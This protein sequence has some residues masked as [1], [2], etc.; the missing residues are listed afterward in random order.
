MLTPQASRIRGGLAV[1]LG[2]A[3]LGVMPGR[4]AAPLGPTTVFINELH[5][6]NTGTDTGEAIEVAGPAGTD[7]TGWSLV[8][9][10]GSVGSVYS[11]TSL[12]SLIPHLSGGFGV[13]VVD[14]PTNG[15]QN[16]SPDGIALVD[17]GGTVVQFLSYEG[18]FVA[19]G[20]PADGLTSTDI[21]VA[22]PSSTPVG[23]SLQLMGTGVFAEDF[24]WALPSPHTFG[25]VNTGQ[26]FGPPVPPEACGDPSTTIHDVQGSGSASPLDGSV[27]A[28]EGVVV[29][30]F[31]GPTPHSDGFFLQEPDA[32]ADADPATSE[33]IFV[34]APGAIDVGSGDRVRVRGTVGEFFERT[35]ITDVSLVLVCSAGNPLPAPTEL[36]LPVAS[37]DAFERVEGMRVRFPQALVIAEYFNFDRFGEIVLSSERRYQPTA[38]VE[39]GTA[40]IALA[41][42]NALDQI[43]LDDGR[44]DQNP[45]PARHPNGAVFDLTN[46]FRGGDTVANLTGVMDFGFG[47]YRVQ[48]TEGAVYTAANRRPAEPEAVGGNVKVASFNLLN[49]FTTLSSA[50]PVCGPAQDQD[51]RGADDATELQRQQDKIVSALAALGAD[52]VG[53]LELENAPTDA[54]LQT[55]VQALN[56]VVGA[57]TY[58]SVATG[59]IG[60]D[61]IKVAFLYKPASVATLGPHA[62]LDSTV[63][64]R[65]LDTKNRPALAQTFRHTASGGVFTS[66]VNHLKSKGSGC[67]DV[68]DPDTGDGSGNCNGTRQ[69]AARALVDWLATDPTGSGDEDFLVLGDL[70][71]YAKE[72]PIDALRARGYTD[73]VNAFGGELAY[74]FVFDGQLGYLH[75]ALA[76]QGLAGEVTGTSVWHIN[77]DEPDLLDYDTSFK[78][79]AQDALYE[80]NAFRSSDHDPVLVGLGV[81]DELAP[82]LSVSVSP[83]TLQPPNHRYRTVTATVSASDD[84]DPSPQVRLV[85]V[86]SSEPDNGIDDGNTINDIVVVDDLTLKL[87]AERSGSGSGRT[88]TITYQASDR[89]GNT[90]IQTATVVVPLSRAP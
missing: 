35:E 45:D 37:L 87:R 47:L 75:H 29:G 86:T 24:T 9:Y 41:Q 2:L 16:G 83:E 42:A 3:L 10:N 59:P 76:S 82:I 23:S 25:A 54:P 21:G 77:A 84:T 72:D 80:P 39:P 52:V 43:T 32:E 49:Y 28:V 55:L 65:F 64:P 48:A 71:S 58:A 50:G 51:C 69:A 8:L 4:A 89:C 33:G 63:D 46:R 66:V 79:P 31:Q 67:D 68:G 26:T 30:D 40:A 53:L 5:Y 61:A 11:T 17:P 7:L 18:T 13:V 36:A 73:L 56:D 1:G 70:N 60:T 88:Y 27:V 6:D 90:T 19:V 62:I 20:G 74:S 22:E 14:Y 81:C 15:I 44:T 34:F 78:Q 85:S 12:S 57:G 38:R